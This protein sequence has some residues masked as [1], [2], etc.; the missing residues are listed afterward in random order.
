MWE[1]SATLVCLQ[2]MKSIFNT[3][4]QNLLSLLWPQAPLPT[5]ASLRLCQAH[6][7][8]KVWST[9]SNTVRTQELVTKGDSQTPPQTYWIR[10]YMLTRF[11]GT[12]LE[13]YRHRHQGWTPQTPVQT[14]LLRNPVDGFSTGISNS[15]CP[16]TQW[17]ACRRPSL[18]LGF[19]GRWRTSFLW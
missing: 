15:P 2:V 16:P 5:C 18:G 10:T 9:S 6:L 7:P 17:Q 13:T 12:A 1:T 4:A 19:R 8:S 11:R 14:P 3:S